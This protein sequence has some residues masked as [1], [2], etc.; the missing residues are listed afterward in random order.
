[1]EKVSV[2]KSTRKK[3]KSTKKQVSSND[4]NYNV[5]KDSNSST[6]DQYNTIKLHLDCMLSKHWK[7]YEGMFKKKLSHTIMLTGI[8]F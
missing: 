7:D 5:L 3:A 2:T 6:Q 8:I 4:G 1:M